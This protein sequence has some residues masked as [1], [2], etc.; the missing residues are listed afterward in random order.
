[1]YR[2]FKTAFTV[3]PSDHVKMQA[4][5]QKF[6]E[7]AVSKTINMPTNATIDD[8]DTIYRTAYDLGCVGVTVYRDGSRE[9][10]VLTSN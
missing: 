3:A 9:G 1:M 8:V 6:T 4:V 5:W 10:Q 7:N 2:I